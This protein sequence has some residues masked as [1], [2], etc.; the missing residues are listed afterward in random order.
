MFAPLYHG[1]T[2]RVAGIR[3]QLGV[4]TTFNLLGPLTN[5]AGAPRQIIGVWDRSLVEP[6]AHT[7]ALL[8]TERAW[9]VHGADGLDE[10]TV[11]DKTFVAEAHDGRVR[12]FEIKPEDF[13]FEVTTLDHLRVGDAEGNAAII[14]AVLSGERAD[15]A[16]FLVLANAAAAL[17]VGGIAGDLREGVILAAQSINSGAALGKLDQ[18]I[19]AGKQTTS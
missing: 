10:I 14:R 18:L 19:E 9:V 12:V 2:A 4:Q 13:G 5:P 15:A 17:H 1:A 6:L 7:L 8:G 11:S 3:R 16:R